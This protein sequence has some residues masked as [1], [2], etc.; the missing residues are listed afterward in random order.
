ML[1]IKIKVIPRVLNGFIKRSVKLIGNME[2]EACL[3]KAIPRL[4]EYKLDLKSKYRTAQVLFN[5]FGIIF[6]ER[7]GFL[8]V[9]NYFRKDSKLIFNVYKITNKILNIF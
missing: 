8:K 3:E 1:Q 5:C 2:G 9:E 7:L 4:T 6:S